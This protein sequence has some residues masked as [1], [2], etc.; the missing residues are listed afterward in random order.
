VKSSELRMYVA[1]AA[2]AGLG[3]WFLQRQVS[4][5]AAS[6]G[7]AVSDAWNTATD[8]GRVRSAIGNFG[9]Y[10]GNVAAGTVEGIGLAVGI[11]RT[12]QSKCQQDLS[13]GAYWDASFSCPAGDFISGAAAGVWGSTTVQQ[14]TQADVR[15]VDNAIGRPLGADAFYSPYGIYGGI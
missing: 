14:A 2:V 15:R 13:A 5:A 3:L 9:G 4:G 11:P 7:G 8:G 1:L 10:V 6:I 12:S